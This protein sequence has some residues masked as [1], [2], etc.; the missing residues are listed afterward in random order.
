MSEKIIFLQNGKYFA[1]ESSCVEKI[2]ERTNLTLIPHAPPTVEGLINVHGR[3]VIL[4]NFSK[5]I[6]EPDHKSD[7]ENILLIQKNNYVYGLLIGSIIEKK[8]IKESDITRTYKKSIPY[9]EGQFIYDAKTVVLIDILPALDM[10]GNDNIPSALSSDIPL[11]FGRAS[12]LGEDLN[13]VIHHHKNDLY[14]LITQ[15]NDEIFGIDIQRIQEL[16]TIQDI[17]STHFLSKDVLGIIN[18]RNVPLLVLSLPQIIHQ[19]S[20]YSP[21]KYGM[22]VKTS[23]GTVIFAIHDLLKIERFE[24]GDYHLFPQSKGEIKGWLKG[25]DKKFFPIIDMDILL[26][27]PLFQD[28]ENYINDIQDDKMEK[29]PYQNKRYLITKIHDEYCGICLDDVKIVV[30]DIILQEL[31]VNHNHSPDDHR[32]IMGIANI[33]GD[34][35]YIVDSYS[36]FHKQHKRASFK[37]Y[38]VINTPQKT[39]AISIHSVDHVLSIDESQ[40]ENIAHNN[41]IIKQIAK[42]DKKLISLIDTKEI[43]HFLPQIGYES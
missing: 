6:H 22:I 43:L 16:I 35:I 13:P 39:F 23:K 28:L 34:I 11:S 18:L 8:M 15:I 32:H 41:E 37:N 12:I 29:N 21:Y 33:H 10:T 2:L 5:I 36:L 1:I 25:G 19:R 7:K 20:I 9:Y 31:P 27:N 40:I 4:Y 17:T 26:E 3:I 24:S 38:V 42:V 14:Y 30:D